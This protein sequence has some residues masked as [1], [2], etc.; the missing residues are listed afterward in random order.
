MILGSDWLAQHS[1]MWI[2]WKKKIMKFTH[3]KKRVVLKG[4]TDVIT[5]CKHITSHKLKGLLKKKAVQQVLKLEAICP[6]SKQD[7]KQIE[8]PSNTYELSL[9]SL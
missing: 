7:N 4:V 6:L 2:H 1:P 5:T 9:A 8:N 3:Q